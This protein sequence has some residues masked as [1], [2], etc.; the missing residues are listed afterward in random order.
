[1]A[2]WIYSVESLPNP[3]MMGKP[4]YNP[5][6]FQWN[7]VRLPLS[8]GWQKVQDSFSNFRRWNWKDRPV[9]DTAT[10][11]D[12]ED[13]QGT[14]I[15]GIAKVLE[16]RW[17]SRG[18]IVLS[19]E[20]KEHEKARYEKEANDANLAFRMKAVEAYEERLKQ[21]AVGEKVSSQ[22]TLYEDECYTIL[23]ITKPYSVEAMRA[24]REPGRVV[25]EDIS[26]A[27]ERLMKRL[28]DQKEKPVTQ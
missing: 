14:P 16:E 11:A 19:R 21:R 18:V 12:S 15:K 24:Q 3:A 20:P 23:G 1:M 27:L 9:R 5:E 4:G 6:C 28:D 22:V 2:Y 13:D 25:A 8:A 10:M 26:N 17:G 7:G